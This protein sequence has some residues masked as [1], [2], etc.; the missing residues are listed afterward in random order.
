MRTGAEHEPDFD[1]LFGDLDEQGQAT[2]Y[3]RLSSRRRGASTNGSVIEHL[4]SSH[5]RAPLDH[6]DWAN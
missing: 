5:R 2:P 1:A 6:P 3:S 4:I